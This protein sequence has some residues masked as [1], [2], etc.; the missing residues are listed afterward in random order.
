MEALTHW[1]E[2]MYPTF[3]D[4]SAKNLNHMIVSGGRIGLQIE[5]SPTDLQSMTNGHLVHI[6]KDDRLSD[7]PYI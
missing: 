7:D 2:K 4:E 5:I 1:N 6:V 3:I